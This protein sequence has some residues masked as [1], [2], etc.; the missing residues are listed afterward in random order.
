MLG[1]RFDGA[2]FHPFL[3]T[4]R[5][6]QLRYGPLGPVRLTTDNMTSWK[7][8]APNTTLQALYPEIQYPPVGKHSEDYD[9]VA[10]VAN[11]YTEFEK[12]ASVYLSDLEG[13]ALLGWPRRQPPS[14]RYSRPISAPS[15][16]LST[17]AHNTLPTNSSAIQINSRPLTTG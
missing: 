15:L 5:G 14:R 17:S 8:A 2:Q 16:R 4:L 10:R 9:A 7:P 6:A 1:V 12:D 11:T 13:K 3:P